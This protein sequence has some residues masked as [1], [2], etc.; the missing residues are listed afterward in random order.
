MRTLIY[1]IGASLD[2]FIAGPEGEIDSRRRTRI[3]IAWV[4]VACHRRFAGHL[5]DARP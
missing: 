1:P 4:S 5:T 3:C 2:G